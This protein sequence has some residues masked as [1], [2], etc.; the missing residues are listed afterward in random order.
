MSDPRTPAFEAV[1]A[2]SRSGIFSDPGNVTALHNLL[3]AFGAP[4]EAGPPKITV[5]TLAEIMNHESVVLEWYKD[6][7]GIGTWGVGITNASG[8][9]VDRYKDKP[10]T[11]QH[12]L[13]VYAWLLKEKYLP[14]VIKAFQGRALTEAQLTAALSFHY[15]TGAILR[16]D[17]VK[18]FLA[19][20]TTNA[21]LRF[22]DWKRPASII[23]R[24]EKERDLF[25]NGI[26]SN[27]GMTTIWP[28]NKPSYSPN[29]AKPQRVNLLP[30]LEKLVC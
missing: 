24:R 22:M 10:Q 29:W 25:F 20:D 6:G 21:R 19:G 9:A 26:W 15:N 11:I 7:K 28:V 8:H 17:W 30:T 27:D 18:N 12:C 23:E 14:D 5:Q 16:A 3:D 13:E 2:I 1:R 4:R